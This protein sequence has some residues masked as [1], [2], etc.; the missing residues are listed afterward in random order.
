MFSQLTTELIYIFRLAVYPIEYE[1]G[2]ICRQFTILN[3]T[4]ILDL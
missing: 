4:W 1:T 2:S 3:E